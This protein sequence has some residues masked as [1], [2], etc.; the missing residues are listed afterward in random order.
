MLITA[1]LVMGICNHAIAENATKEKNESPKSKAYAGSFSCR[2]CHEKFYQIW[3]TSFH[4]LAMQPYTTELAQTKLTP[5]EKEIVIGKYKYRADISGKAGYIVETDSKGEKK[6][7]IEHVMG[8]KN[9]YYFLTLLEKGRLQTLPVAYDVNKKEW[10]DTAASGLRHFPGEQGRREE[11]VNWKEWPYTFNTACYSCHV[12]QLS[13]NYNSKA[14][15]YKTVWAEPGINC[16]TCHGPGDEHNKIA[17]ATPKG[18]PL[19]EMKIISTKTMTTEQ[20]NHLCASC[21]AKATAP[22]TTFYSPG[23]RFFDHFDLVTLDNPD[24]YP[25]GRDLGENYTY[26]SWM[27]SPCVKSGKLDCMH[28]HTSS[29]R[30]R[31]KESEKANSACMPCHADRVNNSTAHTHHNAD[32]PGSKC[33]SCHMPMTEFARMKRSDHSML[34]PTPSATIAFK[35]PNACNICH[36]DKDAQWADNYVRK[37]RSRDYQVAVMHRAGL[38]DA[39][40]KRDWSRLQEM[41]DYITSKDRDEIFAASLIRMLPANQ[42]QRILQTLLRAI[43]DPSPL[44]RASAAES[45]ALMPTAETLQAL[46]A[47]LSDDYRLVRIRSAA[48]LARFSNIFLKSINTKNI[49]K[50]NGEFLAS[51]MARPDQWTSHYN[52]GNYY[53]NRAELKQ[54]VASYDKALKLEPRAVMAMVNSSLAYAGMGEDDKA[55]KSLQKALKIAPDNAAA[56]FNLGLLKAEQKDFKSA[57]KYLKEALKYDPQMA[58]A[59]YNLCVMLAKDRVD[60]AIGF[61]RKA[62]EIRPDD[63]KYAYTLAFFQQQKGDTESAT[64]TLDALITRHPAYLDAYLLLAEIYEKEGKKEDVERVYNKALAVEGAPE[65]FRDHI[66]TKLGELKNKPQ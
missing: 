19:K 37:W 27:M 40:R 21:H 59:A 14:D 60:E 7:K 53:L 63:P 62:S 54:A 22:L 31:F 13:T 61:C 34:P 41:L 24:Y 51:L 39:A 15:T 8:G 23:E 55:D 12:S 28:C 65:S 50:A 32:S 30:Y 49:E 47:A 58:K 33:V 52:M 25:D 43:E 29:G 64:R 56:N 36:T 46:V 5:Q 38:I 16:E 1:M 11:P 45:I 48:V 57:E 17:R 44:V 42:D 26:T 35:S 18:Q 2:E 20:R 10:F 4:G 9:V 66:R 6:Y 3:S